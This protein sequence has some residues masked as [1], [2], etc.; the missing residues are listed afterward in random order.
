MR[1]GQA[2]FLDWFPRLMLMMVAIIIIV[3]LVRFFTDRDLQDQ[4]VHTAAIMY[5]I[6]YDDI[7]MYSDPLTKRVY[8]GIIDLDKWDRFRANDIF[9]QDTVFA[10]AGAKLEIID[11]GGCGSRFKEQYIFK[12]TFDKIYSLARAGVIGRQSG[13][14]LEETWPVTYKRGDREC[15]GIMKVIVVV[16]NA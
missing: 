3:F 9:V 13:T 12:E 14:I 4:E 2:E 8:P 7:I 5:R 11:D 10:R 6:Y 1:K 16:Q 15:A